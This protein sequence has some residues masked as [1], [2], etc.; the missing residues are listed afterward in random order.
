MWK[1]EV[2]CVSFSLKSEIYFTCFILGVRNSVLCFSVSCRHQLTSYFYNICGLHG[3]EGSDADL[4]GL[5]VVGSSVILVNTSNIIWHINWDIILCCYCISF[6]SV[7]KYVNSILFTFLYFYHTV[8]INP[9]Y[10]AKHS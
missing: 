2:Q 5:Y 3:G 1:I 8:C 9:F 4:L 7:T 10:Y 6:L